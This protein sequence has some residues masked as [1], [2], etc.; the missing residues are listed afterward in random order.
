[1]GTASRAGGDEQTSA[2][3]AGNPKRL[4]SAR[5]RRVKFRKKFT[6]KQKKTVVAAA[7]QREERY[8]E[9][10]AQKKQEWKAAIV[11]ANRE[12]NRLIAKKKREDKRLHQ[13]R[14]RA[15]QHQRA[16]EEKRT[17]EEM[18]LKSKLLQRTEEYEKRLQARADEKQDWI[19]LGGGRVIRPEDADRYRVQQELKARAHKVA[20]ERVQ[21]Q[22]EAMEEHRRKETQ[23]LF[24]VQQEQQARQKEE[25]RRR[26]LERRRA[27][28]KRQAECER[29]RDLNLRRD[30]VATKLKIVER[31]ARIKH[32]TAHADEWRAPTPQREFLQKLQDSM[33]ND[34]KASVFIRMPYAAAS[35]KLGVGGFLSPL[36]AVTELP[37]RPESSNSRRTSTTSP[38]GTSRPSTGSAA[39][40]H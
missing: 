30:R 7:R 3:K 20:Q 24:E 29:E 26:N 33:Y 17:E 19:R 21:E 22:L 12:R 25:L 13:T 10:Q 36:T 27:I 35:D 40:V 14:M 28:E 4:L 31:R 39:Q 18:V 23:R 2:K 1:M 37:N 16:V 11:V 38:D 5:T 6:A 9:Q 32:H 15:L 34:D 8:S